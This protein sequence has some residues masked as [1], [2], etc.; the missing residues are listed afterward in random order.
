MHACMH[1]YVRRRTSVYI[2]IYMYMS[3]YIHM[4]IYTHV[5]MTLEFPKP[6]SN[7]IQRPAT[8]RGPCA[9]RKAVGSADGQVRVMEVV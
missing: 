1:A 6:S 7:K 4:F 2:Y 3:V 5:C 9:R 8:V